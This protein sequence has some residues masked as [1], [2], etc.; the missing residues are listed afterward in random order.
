VNPLT[1]H[2]RMPPGEP[3]PAAAMPAFNDARTHAVA[4]LEAAVRGGTD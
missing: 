2:R 3:I 1:E 4:R